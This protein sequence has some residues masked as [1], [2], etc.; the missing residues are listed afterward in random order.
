[1]TYERFLRVFVAVKVCSPDI[2]ERIRRLQDELQNAGLK[3]KMVEEENMHL[4]LQFIGE[5]P[6]EK[7]SLIQNNLHEVKSSPF[8][9]SFEGVGAF[10]NVR[11]PRVIWIGVKTGSDELT[12]LARMVMQAVMKSRVRVE[13]EE[14]TPHLT[15]ARVKAPINSEVRKILENN[16][17][18]YFGEQEV[19]KFYLIKSTLTP[20][21]P[22]YTVIEEYP[23]QS[24]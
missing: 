24:T 7:V 15:I 12:S 3:A 13:S 21:G 19:T 2:L 14:F 4:T 11:N 23:L 17:T 8:S 18:T 20:K 1:M 5:I 22:I 16:G 9:I 10:P 6:Y